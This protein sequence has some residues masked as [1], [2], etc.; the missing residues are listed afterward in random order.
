MS[1]VIFETTA[2]ESG[3]PSDVPV[4][5][6]TIGYNDPTAPAYFA[7]V[8]KQS[9]AIVVSKAIYP[10]RLAFG[11]G[12][13]S[14][15]VISALNSDGAFDDYA[16][17]GWGFSA[18]VKIGNDG[19]AYGDLQPVF[20]G[21]ITGVALRRDL[22]DFVWRSRYDILDKP[23]SSSTFAGT[24][25]LEGDADTIGGQRKPRAG[26]VLYNIDPVLI[27]ATHR[28][29]AWNYDDAGNRAPSHSIDEVRLNGSAWTFHA[30]YADAA[31]LV[32]SNP[33]VGH[34]N[35]CKAE[36]L[37]KM[38]GSVAIDGNVR[39]DVTI[40]ATAAQRYAG[41]LAK[42]LLIEAG[43]GACGVS[44]NALDT[45]APYEAGYYEAESTRKEVIDGLLGS[46]LA[47]AYLCNDGR[48][49]A[50]RLLEPANETAVATLR[51]MAWESA[52]A[53]DD[54]AIFDIEP[55]TSNDADFGA[56]AKE[57]RINY[58]WNRSPLDRGNVAAAVADN[59][60][61]Q[62][63]QEWRTT[64][65]AFDGA[66]AAQFA[67]AAEVLH[68]TWLHNLADA[69]AVRD[70]LLTIEGKLRRRYNVKARLTPELAAQ[71]TVGK[72]VHIVYNRF[73]FDA[74]RNALVLRVDV[75]ASQR[76]AILE[77]WL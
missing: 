15:A 10:S 28:I 68:D 21:R 19:D 67:N 59:I 22:I 40:E 27:D 26:G 54:I 41:A 43:L 8:L 46:V 34:Y 75:D 16:S 42:A 55:V 57:V 35:T 61:Q 48:A 47:C 60:K 6:G 12:N 18:T 71:V 29:F 65:P 45:A 69:Q 74:G 9:Q 23:L 52:A 2:K 44:F 31:A 32:A 33:S 17:Y 25:G 77:V 14:F 30:D 72:V 51:R 3:S 62:L 66:I 50:V 58:R 63:S 73:G 70:D 36:S 56:P 4:R 20:N 53:D 7:P 5:L 49:Y 1:F 76:N 64:A 39:F 13:E 37:V 11:F 24:G 38:G